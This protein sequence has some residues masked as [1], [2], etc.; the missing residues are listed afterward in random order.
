MQ[1]AFVRGFGALL[2]T[3]WAIGTSYMAAGLP[4]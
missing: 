3:V 1:Q 4:A 2:G